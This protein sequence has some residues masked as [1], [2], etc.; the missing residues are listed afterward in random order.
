MRLSRTRPALDH[1]GEPAHGAF[2]RRV[3][4]ALAGDDDAGRLGLKR[5]FCETRA[6]VSLVAGV[7]AGAVTAEAGGVGAVAVDEVVDPVADGGDAG[8][9]EDQPRLAAVGVRR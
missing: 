1:W 5:S 2:G 8:G 7:D 9:G 4:G 6:T 3:G